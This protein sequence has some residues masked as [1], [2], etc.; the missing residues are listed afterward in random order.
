MKNQKLATKPKVLSLK[1][2]H[3]HKHHIQ[4]ILT[5]IQTQNFKHMLDAN[6]PPIKD[7]KRY[8]MTSTQS[9]NESLMKTTSGTHKWLVT[10]PKHIISIDKHTKVTD[11]LM[12]CIQ[13]IEP[14]TG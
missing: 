13:F 7:T 6:M 5:K 14:R 8:P 1:Q 2:P 4:N 9:Q 12:T 10:K 11:K 3:I